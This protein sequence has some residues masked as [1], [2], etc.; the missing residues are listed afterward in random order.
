MTAIADIDRIRVI[1]GLDLQNPRLRA[2]LDEITSR[3]AARLGLPISLASIVLDT[4]QFLAGSHGVTGWIAEA[5]GTP[6]E[7]SFCAQTVLS[8]EPYV[9]PDATRSE[10][11]GN[12][13]VTEDGFRSYAGMPVIVDGAVLGAH[14]VIGTEPHNFTAGELAQL[15]QSA[16]EISELLQRYRVSS[17]RAG[18]ARP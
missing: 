7:W 15:E 16:R 18:G 8:G 9:V 17:A 12:P 1:A 2:D 11:A 14:C 6:V 10:Q 4:A 5:G 13:L 3:T